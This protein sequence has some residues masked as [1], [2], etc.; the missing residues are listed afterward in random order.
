MNRYMRSFSFI[1]SL[2]S[3]LLLASLC[4][5]AS[6]SESGTASPEGMGFFP[7]PIKNGFVKPPKSFFKLKLG[8]GFKFK[9]G[10]FGHHGLIPAPPTTPPPTNSGPPVGV[11]V[12]YADF[13]APNNIFN[14]PVLDL[15]TRAFNYSNSLH[16]DFGTCYQ[17]SIIGIPWNIVPDGTP[18]HPMTFYYWDEADYTPPIPPYPVGSV[19]YPIPSTYIAEGSVCPGGPIGSGDNHDS[20]VVPS[21]GC[22]FETSGLN[23]GYSGGA[24]AVWNLYSNAMRPLDWTSSDAA[25]LPI[26]PLLVKYKEVAAAVGYGR[27]TVGHAFRFTLSS[28]RNT[29]VWPASHQAG[30]SSSTLW[31]MGTRIALRPDYDVSGFSPINQVILNTM[32]VYGMFLADNGSNGYVSGDYDPNWDDSDLHNLGRVTLADFYVVDE[33]PAE[34]SPNSYQATPYG[35]GPASA[36]ATG[37]NTGSVST[38]GLSTHTHSAPRAR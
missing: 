15:P 36:A 30:S 2:Q 27:G 5:P 38:T 1:L 16:A 20:F 12:W 13:V 6:A 25:G 31:P 4:C 11:S 18:L 32:K 9:G 35:S 10:F 37:T 28:T 17:G 26:A 8:W 7:T 24:G 33:T 34:L 14:R 19:G 22:L 29:Y 3:I 23:L 21:T